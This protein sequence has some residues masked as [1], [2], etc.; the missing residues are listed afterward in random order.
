[1]NAA[2]FQQFEQVVAEGTVVVFH[3]LVPL[4]SL[5]GRSGTSTSI[6]SGVILRDFAAEGSGV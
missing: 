3:I 6:I 2:A 1:V 4:L 5:R